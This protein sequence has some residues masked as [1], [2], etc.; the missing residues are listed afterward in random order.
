MDAIRLGIPPSGAWLPDPFL[1]CRCNPCPADFLILNRIF[2]A[3]PGETGRGTTRPGTA[4]QGSF[5]TMDKMIEIKLPYPPTINTYYRH[6][7]GKTLI[8]KKGREYRNMV[9]GYCMIHRIRPMEGRLKM[10]ILAFPPDRRRRDMD[11]IQKPLLDALQHGRAFIDD[12]QIDKLITERRTVERGGYV[13][14]KIAQ[15]NPETRK[16]IE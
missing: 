15:W 4:R 12:S 6:P 13:V 9:V 10:L 16:V 14:V 7:H 11:N 5:L 3:G 1:S 2:K 8:S